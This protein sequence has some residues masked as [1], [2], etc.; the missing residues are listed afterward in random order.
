MDSTFIDI[1]KKLIAEQGKEALL[2]PG[3]S[4]ALLADYARGEYK[5]ESR[6]LLTEQ[7]GVGNYRYKEK[8]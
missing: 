4:K 3:K 2:N 1:L 6:F 8:L 5:K 7:H